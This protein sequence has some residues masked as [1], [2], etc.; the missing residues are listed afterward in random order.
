MAQIEL[1]FVDRVRV[2]IVMDNVTDPLLG[3]QGRSPLLGGLKDSARL[4]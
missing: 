2:T 1:E 3:D 4:F